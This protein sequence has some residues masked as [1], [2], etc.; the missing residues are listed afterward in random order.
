MS[1]DLADANESWSYDE[2]FDLIHVQQMAGSIKD[3]AYLC[4]QAMK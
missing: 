2:Q 3:W 4:G 1:F